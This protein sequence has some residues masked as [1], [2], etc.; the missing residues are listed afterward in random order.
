MLSSYPQVTLSTLEAL[1]RLGKNICDE[2]EKF[3]PDVVI[4]LAHSGWMPVVVAQ[5]LWAET[6]SASF[7]P[8][9]RTNIGQEK[10]EIYHARYGKSLPAICCGEC[11]WGNEGRGHFLA[12]V[13]EQS[14]WQRTLRKQIKAI[15]PSSPKR[16][17]VVDDL[18]G[19]YLSGYTVLGLLDNLYPHIEA[20]VCTG[21]SDLTDNFVTG[22]LAEFIPPLA[23]EI[24][25]NG[26]DTSKVRFGSQW[27]K[28]LKPL[29]NGTED[30]ASDSLDWKL[31]TRES[32]AV[33]AVA[34]YVPAEVALSAPQWAKDQACTYA[35]KRLRDEIKDDEVVEPGKEL[36]HFV[37]ITELSLTAEERLLARGWGHGGVDKADIVR[38]YGD[39]PKQMKVGLNDVK[40]E[41]DWQ[42]YGQ[43]PNVI[44]FPAD[45]FRSWIRG[46]AV[47]EQTRGF[48]E[49]LPGEIWAGVYPIFA[50]NSNEELF[51]DL[52][53]KGISRFV[54]LTIPSEA[55]GKLSYRK[56][57]LQVSHDMKKQV[58]IQH[59]PLAFGTAPSILQ[60]RHALKYI[61]RALKQGHRVYIHAGYNLEGRT[62]LI[63]ACLLI[64]RG[65]S[66]KK[67]LA[68][69]NTF[70][71]KTLHY[72]IRS[73]LSEDQRQFILDWQ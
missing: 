39:D 60:V 11:C 53:D 73:P 55:H 31:I 38:I 18:F 10:H 65:Y 67:A 20:Y 48:D 51:K 5:T 59:F 71:M 50:L 27:Q 4:G 16:I 15:L 1:Y 24:L 7:P 42:T 14:N 30:I 9:M 58:E 29:I 68:K 63:L 25:E 52:L 19:G 21:E 37:E 61:A 12:W 72:L 64:E 49:F 47:P 41:H 62:P 43:R 13:A 54:D 34:E 56:T 32:A 22:W 28:I 2:I 8:S 36:A 70:W 44:Y 17:L 35:L 6:R 40:S 66:A 23:K 33:K 46:N 3:H 26:I 57:L 45:S 69:V